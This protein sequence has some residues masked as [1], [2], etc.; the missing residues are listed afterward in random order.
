MKHLPARS[1]TLLFKRPVRFRG[2]TLV[3]F[4]LVLPVMLITIFVIIELARLLHA[5]LAVENGAR[6]GVRFAVTGEYDD[7]YCIDGS[8]PGTEACEGTGRYDERNLARLPSID[9]AARAGAVGILR[10]ETAAE[11]TRGHFNISICSNHQTGATPDYV[12]HDSIPA[13]GLDSWCELASSPGTEEEHPGGPGDRVSVTVDFEHPLIVPILSNWLPHIHLMARR[14][15]IVEQFRVA[16]VVGLPATLS[17]ATWTATIT[18]TPTNTPTDTATPTNSPTLCKVPPEVE[19]HLPPAGHNYTAAEKVQSWATAY[20]PDNA[21][22]VNCVGIGYDGQGIDDDLTGPPGRVEFHLDYWDPTLSA[23]QLNIYT[24]VES[25]SLFCGFG[26]SSSC[27]E[28]PVTDGNWPSGS[29]MRSG[30]HRFRV[31]AVDDEGVSST[32]K[33]VQFTIDVP[34][35]PTPT[36]TPTVTVTPTP[37]C[38]NIVVNG[39]YRSGDKLRM[40][41]RNNN[42]NTIHLTGSNTNWEEL[43]PSEFFNEARYSF[44]QY[45]PGDDYDS[46]TSAGP[47]NPSS[48][49]HGPFAQ[50]LWEA[51]FDNVPGGLIYG[52][53]STTLTFDYI[54]NVSA[55][56]SYAPPTATPTATQTPTPTTTPTVTLTPPPTNTP[57]VTPTPSCSGVHFG[58]TSFDNYGRLRLGVTNTTYPGLRITGITIDWGPLNTAS[59]L[60]GWN[61]HVDWVQWNGSQVYGGNDYT[62]TTNTGAINAAVNSSNSIYIDWDGG[63]EGHFNDP[64]LNLSA[65]NFGFS[66]TFSDP[67]CN[68][69]RPATSSSFP[70][71]TYTPTVTRTATWTLTPTRTL[72]P[73][74]TRTPTQTPTPTITSTSHATDTPTETTV[75]T[76]TPTA[77]TIEYD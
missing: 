19:I 30:L 33:A 8:D 9:D 4:A 58:S 51:D 10:D 69:S 5:W 62:S 57:T 18:P 25:A 42:P 73:T 16:R 77:T 53:Y 31:W 14:E 56:V 55:S 54:C 61:E 41:V 50:L 3:E 44:V 66:I 2:Q 64:P 28:H 23:W 68:I 27:N 15:G 47:G 49:P 59:N 11:G 40:I 26:G 38:S 48:F 20:D 74:P 43:S 17:A 13:A 46:P 75:P 67:S 6:F 70:T 36:N 71:P 7:T 35:T 60:Y 63:F 72:T 39:F 45:Y 29:V 21:D 37:D 12:Y 32:V 76:I 34:P 1:K 65:A 22:P 52:D 24:Q